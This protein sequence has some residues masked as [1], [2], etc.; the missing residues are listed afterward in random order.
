MSKTIEQRAVSILC[1]L[2]RKVG[3][4]SAQLA[5]RIGMTPSAMSLVEN[6]KRGCDMDTFWKWCV[7]LDKKPHHVLGKIWEQD[8]PRSHTSKKKQV[9]R[10]KKKSFGE[11]TAE[12]LAFLAKNG[13]K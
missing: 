4:S 11:L 1:E 5:S 2:R 12:E 6:C 10:L 3:M 13:E 9:E 7:A 8:H